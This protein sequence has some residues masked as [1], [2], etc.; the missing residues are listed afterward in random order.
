MATCTWP[1]RSSV[2]RHGTP[3]T[4]P[5]ASHDD[6]DGDSLTPVTDI[7]NVQVE[8]TDLDVVA[9]VKVNQLWPK[10]VV[11][12]PKYGVSIGGREIESWVP[13]PG[14]ASE[15]VT[16]DHSM[17]RALPS[18]WSE[19]DATANTVTFRIPRS[20]LADA[21]VTAPYDVFALTSYRAP[22][23]LWTLVADDRAPDAGAIGVA[24]PAGGQ[25]AAG[26]GGASSSGS[27]SATAGILDP[28]VLER[29]GG[30]TFTPADSTLGV[31]GG[32]VHE[33][34][35]SVPESSSVE[36]LLDWPDSSDLDMYVTGAATGSGGLRRPARAPRPRG[37]P[38]H[39]G[40]RGQPL[41]RPRRSVDE[42]HAPGDGRPERLWRGRRPDQ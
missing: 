13:E 20:Y 2:G 10:D 1:A 4:S 12:L 38:G 27:G 30:N 37:C 23:K 11:G 16:Y 25:S 42:L 29:P 32:P 8:A 3:P 41:P 22:T 15:V 14:S 18:E 5:T 28:I 26:A 21:K 9:T 39:P 17:E 36:L 31:T 6:P 35:L 7:Q 19:W 34:S 24:A 40:H 33:F